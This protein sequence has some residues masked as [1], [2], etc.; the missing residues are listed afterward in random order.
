MPGIEQISTSLI[1]LV[2]YLKQTKT[3][4]PK[5]VMIKDTIINSKELYLIEFSNPDGIPIE[6]RL[7]NLLND[8]IYHLGLIVDKSTSLPEYIKYGNWI[9][10]ISNIILNSNEHE[11]IWNKVNIPQNFLERVTPYTEDSKNVILQVGTKIPN[12]EFKTIEGNDFEILKFKKKQLIV[13]FSTN[14]GGCIAE[15]PA[16]NCISETK[17]TTVLAVYFGNKISELKNF[18]NKYKIKYQIVINNDSTLSSQIVGFPV[19]YLID[20][21]GKIIYSEL[22]YNPDLEGKIK[23]GF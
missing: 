9:E 6:D 17:N 1:T 8:T 2:Q 7:A 3:K 4:F 5:R 20:E 19:N 10:K 21:N 23:Q 12:W 15:I 22:G 11:K 18:I 16:L 14:C 13:L